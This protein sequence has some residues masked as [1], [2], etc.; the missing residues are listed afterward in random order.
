[1]DTAAKVGRKA[2]YMGRRIGRLLA[3]GLVLACV[4]GFL[5]TPAAYAAATNQVTLPVSQV[6]TADGLSA[7][8]SETFT[9]RLTPETASVPMPAGSGA[10]GY[11]FIITGTADAQIGPIYYDDAGIYTYTLVCVSTAAANYTI[12]RQVYTITVYILNGSAPVT[13]AYLSDEDKAPVI[14]FKQI[15][16]TPASKE[17]TVTFADGRGDTLKTEKVKDGGAAT[18]PGNPQRPGYVFA[19]WDK[20]YSHITSDL[21][22]TAKWIPW[23]GGPETPQPPAV[24]PPASTPQ[25]SVTPPPITPTITPTPPPVAQQPAP[26]AP[27][28][29]PQT[30]GPVSGHTWSLFSCMMSVAAAL[31]AILLLVFMYFRR[32]KY[33]EYMKE[34]EDQGLLTD[35]RIDKLAERWKQGRLPRALAIIAGIVTPIIWLILDLPLIGMVWIDRSTPWITLVFIITMTLTLVFNIRKK[36]PDDENT[37]DADL[38]PI[39][40]K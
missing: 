6:F 40:V 17:W 20:D 5:Q 14:S 23:W 38:N 36:N 19:G 31:T 32:R 10:A 24:P 39:F 27:I 11:T 25:T 18:A 15:Y 30:A 1:V 9:Y 13:V 28:P 16:K 35:D 2:M 12:D 21:T 29:T 7:P 22:V 8:P 3:A 37:K 4:T 34:L 33:E 26:I